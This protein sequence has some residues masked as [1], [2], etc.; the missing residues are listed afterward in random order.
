MELGKDIIAIDK[1]NNVCAF[2]LKTA[3]NGRFN[4]SKWREFEKQLLSLVQSRIIHPSIRRSKPHKSFLVTNGFIDEE[5][6]TLIES[7]NDEWKNNNLPFK[8]EVIPGG[9]LIDW[10]KESIE[11]IFPSDL[12]EFKYLLDFSLE[13]GRDMFPKKSM[14]LLLQNILKLNEKSKKKLSTHHFS[15][16]ISASAVLCSLAITNYSISNNYFAEIEAWMVY[17]SSIFACA[18]RYNLRKN[19]WRKEFEIAISI[20]KQAIDALTNEALEKSSL[21]EGDAIFDVD[22]IYKSR[23][24]LILS[25]LAIQF[26]IK[27]SERNAPYP[28]DFTECWDFVSKIKNFIIFHKSPIYIWGE[29]EMPQLLAIYWFERITDASPKPDMFLYQLIEY[30]CDSNCYTSK[31]PLPNPYYEMKDILPKLL[32]IDKKAILDGFTNTSYCLDGILKIFI[33]RNLK[34]F[35][36]NIWPKITYIN[37]N[38]FKTE[39]LWQFYL[40][41]S[42]HGCKETI[43]RKHTKSWNEIKN[44]S[45]E[46]NNSSIPILIRDYPILLLL[47]TIIYPHRFSTDVIQHLDQEIV[48]S[49]PCFSA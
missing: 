48:Y 11:A 25:L 10:T 30:V 21:W 36:K 45:Y 27:M 28:F 29:A 20:I 38:Q 12:I 5:V 7:Y 3:E 13:D 35:A 33:R 23:M 37:S 17:I 32:G 6:S 18:E 40:Y 1:N 22:I 49:R 9:M 34:S 44:E 41:R 2:Q 47:Y 24:N 31:Q 14:A 26:F 15:R 43:L 8:L 4:M 16:L 46:I 42:P 19:L 39:K